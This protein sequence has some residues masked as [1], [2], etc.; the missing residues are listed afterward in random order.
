MNQDRYTKGQSG[1]G[2]EMTLLGP[3]GTIP[4]PNDASLLC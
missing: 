3:L 4:D 1:L 2:S